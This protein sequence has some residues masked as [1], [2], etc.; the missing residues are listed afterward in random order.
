[1][2]PLVSL[3]QAGIDRIVAGIPG[4]AANVQDIYPLA[5][6]QKG[7][8]FHHLL[9]AEEDPY[10]GRALLA[11]DSPQRCQAFVDGL[12]AVIRRHDILRTSAVWE[13]LP[14]PLQVVWRDAEMSVETLH[15]DPADGPVA[16]Q[17]FE[18]F[19]PRRIPCILTHA[20]LLL[21][22]L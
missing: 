18:H 3:D 4:G 5:S 12:Q 7:I 13:Q 6:L 9:D 16:D 21:V 17:L 19:H 20:P 15:F 14:E 8:L 11:F 1:M 10:L 2:L 22:F